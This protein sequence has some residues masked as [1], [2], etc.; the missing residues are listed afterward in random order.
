VQFLQAWSTLALSHVSLKEIR[1]LVTQELEEREGTQTALQHRV[2]E[3][4]ARHVV[5]VLVLLWRGLGC[6]PVFHV[7]ICVVCLDV[8]HAGWRRMTV[9][10]GTC[11]VYGAFLR[12]SLHLSPWLVCGVLLPGPSLLAPQAGGGGW[13]ACFQAGGGG[14]HRGAPALRETRV[15]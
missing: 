6:V 10:D 7:G 5:G 14:C 15:G 12:P 3:L 1:G 9:G 8:A 11:R 4:E 2:L 13:R